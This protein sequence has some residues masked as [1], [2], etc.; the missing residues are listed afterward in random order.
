MPALLLAACGGSEEKVTNL[1]SNSEATVTSITSEKRDNYSP[2]VG[3]DYPQDVYFGDLHLHTSFSVDAGLV[4]CK[5]GPEDAYRFASGEEVVTSTG[6]K[7]KLN[8][9]LDFLMVSD[10]GTNLGI[11]PMLWEADPDLLANEI[12]KKWYDLVQEGKGKEGVYLPWLQTTMKGID[13]IKSEKIMRNAWTREMDAAEK[14]NQPGVFTAIIGYEWT[15]MPGGNNLHRVVVFKD[16]KEKVNNI[17]P[18]T[19]FDSQDPEDLWKYMSNYEQKYGGSVLAIPHNGNMSDGLMFSVERMNGE[20]IDAEYATNRMK[21]EPLYEVTQIKGD[22]ETHP[23][24]STTDEFAD[25]GTWDINPFKGPAENTKRYET[26]YARTALQIGLQQKQKIG[27]NPFKF[28]M[29]GSTDAHTGLTGW[30]ENNYMGK[31][32][33]SEPSAERYEEVL[34]PSPLDKKYDIMTW[35]EV[36]GGLTA[37]WAK[38]NTREALFDA[39]QQKETYATTGTRLRVRFFA[40]WEY[41]KQDATRSD[42]AKNAYANG[43]PMGSD[44]TDGNGKSPNFLIQAMKDPDGANL[45]RVQVIKGWVDANGERQERIYDVAVSDGRV[46]DKTG[47]CKTSVGSTV[48]VKEATYDNSIG[49]TSMTTY[50]SDPDFDAALDAVYYVRVLEIPTPTWLAYDANFYKL[51]M[52]KEYPMTHQER[53]YTSPIWYAPK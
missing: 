11:P 12:G 43:V 37:V 39:M 3:D 45:D 1:T 51:S 7:A 28:G 35:M 53:A 6:L 32:P 15:S 10:H 42:F 48:N 40:G 17:L 36:A 33:S 5:L 4:G 29:I 41:T 8:R 19:A 31:F 49:S 44:L 27:V 23:K 52:P 16:G 18:F 21:W 24:L 22:G 20:P 2:F 46:I 38:E 9:P 13:Q 34:I 47:R 25:Y 30:Q 14:Y 50:W 26:E